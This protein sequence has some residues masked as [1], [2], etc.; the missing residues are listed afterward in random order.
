VTKQAQSDLQAD[1]QPTELTL[2]VEIGWFSA[3][4]FIQELQVTAKAGP[5]TSA[6]FV[7]TIHAGFTYSSPTLA[8]ID[9]PA[10]QTRPDSCT[11]Y[12]LVKPDG[13][14]S[15]AA[16]FSCDPSALVKVG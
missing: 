12:M 2:G 14:Y 10:L 1:G 3:D 6:N 9:F 7:K 4:E 15:V 5:L 8:G 11:G 16:P 13:S